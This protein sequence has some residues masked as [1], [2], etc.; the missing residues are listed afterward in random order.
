[1]YIYIFFFNKVSGVTC[2]I[3][4]MPTGKATNPPPAKN[5]HYPRKAYLQKKL[6][7]LIHFSLLSQIFKFR[8]SIAFMTFL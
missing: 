5:P 2:H 1:M 3:S 6:I 8:D 4:I 7:I